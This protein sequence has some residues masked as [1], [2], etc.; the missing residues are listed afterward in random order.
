MGSVADTCALTLDDR[1]TQEAE[2]RNLT[3]T[4]RHMPPYIPDLFRIMGHESHCIKT[5]RLKRGF[6][7]AQL[8]ISLVIG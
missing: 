3:P 7:M 1:I 5:S 6:N 2:L 8:P 4:L